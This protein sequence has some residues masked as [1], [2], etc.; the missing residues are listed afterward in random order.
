MEREYLVKWLGRAHAHN[1]WVPESLLLHTAKRKLLNFKRR[2]GDA[3][4]YFLSAEW[5]LPQR[6][7]A[8]RPSPSGPGWEVLVKWQGL[9]Y[10]QCSWE[11]GSGHVF[12]G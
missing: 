8:R 9:G 2:H 3:P 12:V 5:T 6:F 1:E 10:E 11:V 7:V 4:C